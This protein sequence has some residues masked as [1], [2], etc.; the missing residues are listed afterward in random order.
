[1]KAYSR[2]TYHNK[3]KKKEK[4][5]EYFCVLLSRRSTFFFFK[6]FLGLEQRPNAATNCFKFVI[7]FFLGSQTSPPLRV[8]QEFAFHVNYVKSLSM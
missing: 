5:A 1:M 3:K 2:K 6:E 4:K 8:K 7:N